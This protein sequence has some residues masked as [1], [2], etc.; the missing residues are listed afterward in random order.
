M[1]TII[2]MH[3]GTCRQIHSRHKHA[4]TRH[5]YL[6]FCKM[7]TSFQYKIQ[8][9]FFYPFKFGFCYEAIMS[10]NACI[11]FNIEHHPKCTSDYSM[12]ILHIFMTIYT[13]MPISIFLSH[14]RTH[15]SHKISLKRK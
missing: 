7:I 6:N 3:T 15:I 4:I 10:H 12:K 13:I 14:K 2:Q 11:I 9:V 5:A 8:I 1:N